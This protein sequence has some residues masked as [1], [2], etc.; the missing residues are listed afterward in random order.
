M[1]GEQN[2]PEAKKE[3]RFFISSGEQSGEAYG[4]DLIEELRKQVPDKLLHF[5]GLGGSSMEKSRVKLLYHTNELSTIGFLDVVKKINFFRKVLKDSLDCV[6]EI[7]PDCVVLID[8]PGF[9]LKFAEKL[10]DFYTGK[11]IYYI[12]PQLWAW[13]EKRVNIIKKYID[14]VIVVFPFEI[15]FYQKYNIDAVYAG[16]PLIKRI[17]KF[18]EEN[19]KKRK[20]FGDEKVVTFLPGSRKDEINHHLPVLLDVAEQ[21]TKEFDMTINISRSSGV[22]K[23]IFKKFGNRLGKF[24][25]SDENVYSLM[26]NSDLVLT[27]AGTSTVECALI[28]VPFAIFYKTFPLNYYLLK[29]IVKV[30]KL[31]MVNI[32]AKKNI[33][34][35]FVQKDFNP[36]NLLLE[37]R[38]ILTEINYRIKIIGELKEI[39]DILGSQDASSNAA[40]IILEEVL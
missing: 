37:A 11:I 22:D 10:R 14:K 3:L 34:K 31:G 35:E 26:L 30:D 28:G 27:K 36:L 1:A 39:Q 21:L 24:I 20:I 29:P 38:K 15:D 2:I 4:A 40:K 25:L 6:W 5:W 8:Y 23:S 7:K 12:S 33:I 16:H 32:L 13:H 17:G 19:E 18:L 9:N